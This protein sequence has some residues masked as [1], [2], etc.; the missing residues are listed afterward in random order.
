MQNVLPPAP[1]ARLRAPPRWRSLF[2]SGLALVAGCTFNVGGLSADRTA[3]GPAA[4][5]SS[6][7]VDLDLLGTDADLTGSDDAA[8]S[9]SATLAAIAGAD[10]ATLQRALAD[11]HFEFVAQGSTLALS[12]DAPSGGEFLRLQDVRVHVPRA[13]ALELHAGNHFLTARGLRGDVVADVAAGGLWV[14]TEGQV[15]LVA[16]AGAVRGAAGGGTLSTTNGTVDVRWSAAAA[17][18]VTSTSGDVHVQVPRGVGLD[19]DL[20]V[21]SGSLEV[22]LDGVAG[23]G[24]P[25]YV[26]RIGVGG[27]RLQVRCASGF[28]SVTY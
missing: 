26:G 17:L 4:G 24:A 12:Y 27:A 7:R 22:A 10:D 5:W 28:V 3:V 8:P 1:A 19:L 2:V 16:S 18:A 20:A 23:A 21:T 9:A 25:S 13:A 15:Q 14:E 11:A 6:V